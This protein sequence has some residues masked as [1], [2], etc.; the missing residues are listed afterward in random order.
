MGF[1]LDWATA[2]RLGAERQRVRDTSKYGSGPHFYPDDPNHENIVG[3][4]A[5]LV[6]GTAIGQAPPPFYPDWNCDPGYDYETAI[7]FVDVKG[8]S[9]DPWFL[10]VSDT[11]LAKQPG[12]AYYVLVWC[13]ADDDLAIGVGWASRAEMEGAPHAAHVFDPDEE[14]PLPREI[15]PGRW[16]PLSALHKVRRLVTAINRGEKAS[17]W[18]CRTCRPE[19]LA[20]EAVRPVCFG[21]DRPMVELSTY[22]ECLAGVRYGR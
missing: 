18:V 16:L 11:A 12:A 20:F 13:P 17:A 1:P 3:L 21:C 15:V 6:F 7:G 2:Q 8:V 10:P 22:A 4:A 14:R 5:E 19:H 9:K